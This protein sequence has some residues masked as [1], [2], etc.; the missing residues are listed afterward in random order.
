MLAHA[1]AERIATTHARLLEIVAEPAEQ[2][3]WRRHQ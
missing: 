1:L 2:L 3:S